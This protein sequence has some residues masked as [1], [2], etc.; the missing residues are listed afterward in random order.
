MPV[1]ACI[2]GWPLAYAQLKIMIT[3]R[4]WKSP[5]K[6][7]GHYCFGGSQKNPKNCLKTFNFSWRGNEKA[8]STRQNDLSYHMYRYHLWCNQG[9]NLLFDLHH[10]QM[11]ATWHPMRWWRNAWL[12]IWLEYPNYRNQVQVNWLNQDGGRA[13][14]APLALVIKLFFP[15]VYSLGNKINTK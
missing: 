10:S 5:S 8:T 1:V 14:H 13:R 15:H 2:W 4:S 3:N 7:K 11:E 6:L 9:S 12:C